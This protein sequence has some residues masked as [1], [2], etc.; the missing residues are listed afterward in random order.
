MQIILFTLVGATL[1]F[2]ADWV[3]RTLEAR[4]GA[5]FQNRGLIYFAIIMPL[6][7]LVF[8]LMDRFG[9]QM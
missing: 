9:P 2:G 6:A 7:L 8:T 4:R 5:P 1:Y 3:L